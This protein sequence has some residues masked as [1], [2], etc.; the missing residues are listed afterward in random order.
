MNAPGVALSRELNFSLAPWLPPPWYGYWLNPTLAVLHNFRFRNLNMSFRLVQFIEGFVI[1]NDVYLWVRIHGYHQEPIISFIWSKGRAVFFTLFKG[2]L[3]GAGD[4]F[5]SSPGP[6]QWR[7]KVQG[8]APTLR[9]S[10]P[11]P[12]CTAYRSGYFSWV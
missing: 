3:Q 9:S 4:W 7:C 11:Q 5:W 12:F 1:R 10:F 2:D 6:R 8:H